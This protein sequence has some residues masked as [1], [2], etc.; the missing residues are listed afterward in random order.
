M[1]KVQELHLPLPVRTVDVMDMVCVTVMG[2]RQCR[3][4]CGRRSIVRHTGSL[5]SGNACLILQG[6]VTPLGAAEVVPETQTQRRKASP[7]AHFR[8]ELTGPVIVVSTAVL[9]LSST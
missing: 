8:K 7:T 6:T 5:N 4:L 3:G 2:R 1:R 9:L